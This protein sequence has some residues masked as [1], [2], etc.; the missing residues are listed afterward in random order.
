MYVV[1]NEFKG[2]WYQVVIILERTERNILGNQ[3][4]P[5]VWKILRPAT[6]TQVCLGFPVSI[7]KC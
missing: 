7:S 5:S 6:S 3:T 2:R 1:E 4:W